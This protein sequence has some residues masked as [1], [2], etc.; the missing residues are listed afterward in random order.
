ML[1]YCGLHCDTCPI[2]LA[3]LEHDMLKQ[4]DIRKAIALQ[5]SEYY[6]IKMQAKD[7]GDC[8]GCLTT[9][10]ILFSGC[11]T[12]GIR[13][14]AQ[15]KKIENCAYCSDYACDELKKIFSFEPEAKRTLDKIRQS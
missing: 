9:T 13:K 6:G 8:D 10:E 5:C 4:Q 12:C 3:T 14:C 11:L 1:A 2:H 15:L 7:I